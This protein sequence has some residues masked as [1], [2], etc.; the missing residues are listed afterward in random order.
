MPVGAFWLDIAPQVID[1]T[2]NSGGRP[3]VSATIQ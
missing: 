2:T 1:H 3:D